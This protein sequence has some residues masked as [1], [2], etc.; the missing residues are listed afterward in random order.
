M[1]TDPDIVEAAKAPP[2]IV[3]AHQYLYYVRLTPVLTDYDYDMLCHRLGVEGG[4]GSDLASS[5]TVEEKRV[6]DELL[7]QH[8]LT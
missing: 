1:P 2:L 6:A 8:G 7:A 4:G 3:R 5:Y